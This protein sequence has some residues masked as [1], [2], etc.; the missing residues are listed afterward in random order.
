MDNEKSYVEIKVSFVHIIVLLGGVLLIGIFLF[1]LGYQ[2]GKSAAG[3]ELNPNEASA[4]QKAE[5][6]NL[7]VDSKTSPTTRS[8]KPGTSITDEIR[9]HQ[10]PTTTSTTPPSDSS[11]STTTTTTTTPPP[12]TTPVDKT[13]PKEEKVETK[14]ISR[15]PYYAIQVGAFSDQTNAAKYAAKFSSQGYPTEINPSQK[16][17]KTLYRVWVGNFKTRALAQ[18]DRDKL[19]KEESKKF[20]VV[21]SESE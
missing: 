18:K 10:I 15:E 2:A 8:P 21:N 16:S 4:K 7:T 11:S 12:S 14:P 5:E 3:N 17:G 20:S 6:L 9:M 13:P 1:Y 19:E